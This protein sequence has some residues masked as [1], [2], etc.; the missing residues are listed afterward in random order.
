[1]SLYDD[2][3]QPK[4]VLRGP[5]A[6]TAKS[7][8]RAS[9]TP[10]VAPVAAPRI[11]QSSNAQVTHSKPGGKRPDVPYTR[12]Q[13]T[14]LGTYR[15]SPAQAPPDLIA[16]QRAAIFKAIPAGNREYEPA[17]P[18]EYAVIRQALDSHDSMQATLNPSGYAHGQL[19]DDKHRRRGRNVKSSESAPS[20]SSEDDSEAETERTQKAPFV[21]PVAPEPSIDPKVSRIMAK[22]G[23]TVGTGLGKS[24]QGRTDPIRTVGYDGREGLG[25]ASPVTHFSEMPDAKWNKKDS[26]QIRSQVSR[27]RRP[28]SRVLLIQLA[29]RFEPAELDARVR[30]ICAAYGGVERTIMRFDNDQSAILENGEAAELENSVRVYVMFDRSESATT[31]LLALDGS[32][33]LRQEVRTSLYPEKLFRRMKSNCTQSNEDDEDT[34]FNFETVT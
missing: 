31:A 24:K 34:S 27:R 9:L 14:G 29:G 4:E 32:Q 8:K 18:N 10:I 15:P 20:V 21:L 25:K 5:N 13:D 7:L 23:W 30:S 22:M 28:T 16:S 3:P 1:M 33:I 2:I 11:V 6:L 19:F 26:G 17:V 12:P